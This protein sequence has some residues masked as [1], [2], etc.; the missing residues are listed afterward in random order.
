MTENA[1]PMDAETF[2]ALLAELPDDAHTVGDLVRILDTNAHRA[3]DADDWIAAANLRQTQAT[4][5]RFLHDGFTSGRI[6]L[7]KALA[8][9][10]ERLALIE[11]NL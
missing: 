10:R 11:E 1:V 7:P 6:D 3:E 5:L 4:L 8:A 9:T 2:A